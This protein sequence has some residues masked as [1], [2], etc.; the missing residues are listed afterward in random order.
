MIEII[1][2]TGTN[3]NDLDL[4][5]EKRRNNDSKLKNKHK[6]TEDESKKVMNMKFLSKTMEICEVFQQISN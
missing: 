1:V 3:D 4:I 5:C 6:S 2:P